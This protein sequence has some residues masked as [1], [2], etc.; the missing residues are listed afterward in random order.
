LLGPKYGSQPYDPGDDQDTYHVCENGRTY[1]DA[2][3]ERTQQEVRHDDGETTLYHEQIQKTNGSL[4]FGN[5]LYAPL[6][7]SRRFLAHANPPPEV[8]WHI[9][10]WVPQHL[11]P[12]SLPINHS[13]DP[14]R[15]RPTHLTGHRPCY[16]WHPAGD[17]EGTED[18][19]A[20]WPRNVY[21]DA[22]S[23]RGETPDSLS[24]SVGF[25]T[26]QAP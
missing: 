21:Q 10:A 4:D 1:A 12:T 7:H 3:P 5:N 11:F 2:N 9:V 24:D 16:H 19:S 26:W 15:L 25:G 18:Q 8:I 22:T 6:F 17:D 23:G 13:M 14:E 20:L